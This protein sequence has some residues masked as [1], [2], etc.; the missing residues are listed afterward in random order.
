MMPQM[1][2]PR[3]TLATLSLGLA[4]ADPAI[5]L[6][7]GTPAPDPRAAM[8]ERPSV[9]THAH[10]VAPGYVEIETGIQGFRPEIGVTE[11]DTPSLVKVGLTQHVQFDV[12]EGVSAFRQSGHNAFGISDISAGVKW[13][14]LDR[15]PILGDVAV[16]PT[17]KFPT[18]SVDKGTGAGTT[19]LNLLL[20]SSNQLGPVS[21]D[22]NAGVTRRSGDG[23]VVPT[24]ATF[25]TVSFGLAIGH[26]MGWVLE[27]FG[28]PG[29]RGPTGDRPIVAV[30]AGPTFTL[31]PYLVLDCGA[32]V[33]VAG[34]QATA[35]YA[36][37][38][39]NVGRLWRLRK[40]SGA[41]ASAPSWLQGRW[42][43][44]RTRG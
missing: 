16:Q 32:I 44:A 8:P 42:L 12:Y 17:V 24:E 10:T 25:W 31:R 1:T 13:R 11:Y 33:P 6:A 30:T 34:P 7:Q 40:G 2:S 28:F 27:I 22:V 15:A 21:V 19:D 5:L 26:R 35:I 14:I 37:L 39:W 3:L 29:T 18:G 23:S 20:I 9:A 36:G 38:T 4:L 43:D 41:S